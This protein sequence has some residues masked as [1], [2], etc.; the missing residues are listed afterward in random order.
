LHTGSIPV[1]AFVLRGF[2]GY[3]G[4]MNRLG[5]H[6]RSWWRRINTLEPVP[7]HTRTGH[8]LMPD[9]H[10]QSAD[11]PVADLLRDLPPGAGGSGV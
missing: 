5:A 2:G 4:C 7:D 3:A 6:L 1:V 9:D 11:G 8:G 10:T